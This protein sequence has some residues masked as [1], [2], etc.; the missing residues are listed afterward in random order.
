MGLQS[1]ELH[2]WTQALKNFYNKLTEKRRQSERLHARESDRG[3]NNHD[4]SKLQHTEIN[5]TA[6]FSSNED[7]INWP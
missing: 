4:V 5:M 1:L 2:Y 6:L 3:M 7:Q